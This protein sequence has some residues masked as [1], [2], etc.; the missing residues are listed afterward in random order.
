MAVVAA[1]KYKIKMLANKGSRLAKLA[2]HLMERPSHFFSTTLLGTN[3]CTVT[4]SVVTTLYIFEHY[5]EGYATFALLFWPITLIVGE[6]VPKS[7]YQFYANKVVMVIAPALFFFQ[8]LFFPLVWI[9]SQFTDLLIKR[10]KKN[11]HKQGSD[12]SREELEMLMEHGEVEKSDVKP[13]EVTLVSRIFELADKKVENIMTPLVDVI[14]VPQDASRKEA[15]ALIEEHEF[16]RIPLY[17]DQIFNMVG[18]LWSIDLLFDE[19]KKGLTD[20]ARKPYY[21]PEE[22]P[23]DELLFTMKKRGE[24]LAI[25]VDEYGAATGIVTVEDLLEEVV[26]EIGD[27]HDEVLTLYRRLGAKRFVING[28]MEI[29]EANEKLH[30]SIPEGDYETI[31]GFIVHLAGHIPQKGEVLNH[32]KLKITIL[33]ATERVVTEVEVQVY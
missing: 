21:V 22:M 27:E 33:K 4:G 17:D 9:L 19:E 12:F 31:A 28:R 18:V 23:L 26:G 3:I 10:I 16:S 6:L 5:G 11:I 29:E 24:P 7:L 8:I 32:K 14:A 13:S 15:A 25:V 2:L 1:D 30:L 20:L